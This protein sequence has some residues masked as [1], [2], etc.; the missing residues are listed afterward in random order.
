MSDSDAESAVEAVA[1]RFSAGGC[2]GR[3]PI[4]TAADLK[5]IGVSPVPAT[6][7]SSRGIIVPTSGWR[8]LC[9]Y[10]YE[11]ITGL[12]M[13]ATRGKKADGMSSTDPGPLV[14]QAIRD[15]K[16]AIAARLA[17]CAVCWSASDTWFV[18]GTW[19]CAS[20]GLDRPYMP[21]HGDL[22]L[23]DGETATVVS[24][25]AT[26]AGKWLLEITSEGQTWACEARQA[27]LIKRADPTPVDFKLEPTERSA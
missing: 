11:R 15:R 27:K 13:P 7:R 16:A 20:C 6:F 24:Y 22:V 18:E 17:R 26:E 4:V 23:V 14:S 3:R 8:A 1:S 12:V 25:M 9:L 19:L 2:C 21:A 5:L 10:I